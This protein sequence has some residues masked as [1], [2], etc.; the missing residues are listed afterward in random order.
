VA[1]S[2]N[3][4][5]TRPRVL[6]LGG[7]FA[8]AG[9]AQKLADADVDVV[10]V[11]RHDYHTFQ[12]LLYQLATGLLETT[13]VGHSLRDLVGHH[14][15]VTV[16]RATVS[17]VDLD[18]REARFED[19]EPIAYDYLVYGLGA[20]VNFF[21]TEG[22]AEH[23]FPM[24]TLPNAVRLKDH[25]LKRW[26][27]ADHDPT[28]IADGALNVVVVGGG[29]TGVETAGA[30]AEL[31]RAELA[32]D[33]PDIPQDEARVIL[34]EAGPE[35]FSMFKPN[36]REYAAKALTD[37]TVEVRTGEAVAGVSPT[38]VT[39]KS[40]EVLNAHT[41][42]WGAGLQGTPV[43][44]TFGLDLERGNRI[45]VDG[46]LTL[47]GHPEVYV[48]G[49]AA[50]IFDEKTQQVLPQLGSVALQSGEHV[51]ETIARRIA[52]KKTKPFAYKD[53]GTMAAIGRGAACVQMLGGRTM[54]GKKAQMAWVTVHLALLP[55]NEDRAKAIVDLAG[56]TFTHQR[57]GRITVEST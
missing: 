53:K 46:D 55:T 26:D 39:L 17:A 33:Y 14:D 22:A 54:T 23:A 5:S 50:A 6:I 34:V 4:P 35:L 12:P 21:G 51:G 13:A 40:G 20:E 36:L 30:M 15:N 25:L 43:A 7:G 1:S 52:G 29:P 56:A 9:A 32:K 38:R 44:L 28:L 42:V 2:E 27:A 18:A 45:G 8:G 49:D 11:D 31:Y 10:L 16:H 24:Y 41:L 37:R 48:V 57:A 3:S 47:P 19:L